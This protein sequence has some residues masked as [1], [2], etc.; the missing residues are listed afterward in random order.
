MSRPRTER[1]R[2]RRAFLNALAAGRSVTEA[3]DHAGIAWST[4]YS[5]RQS[6]AAF[7]AGW[8][9]ASECAEGALYERLE[10][11]LI[12]R[13]VEGVD[14]PV[15]HN[16]TQIGYRKRYSD[17][18]LL[19]GLRQLAGAYGSSSSKPFVLP[20]PAEAPPPRVLIRKFAVP[21]EEGDGQA[22]VLEAKAELSQ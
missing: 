15:F 5:W 1:E 21:D 11:A 7:A 6:S 8:D 17:A 10:A 9:R 13:A 18:L 19:A 22:P 3:A 12:Q 4:L 20:P 2:R 14:E 16:G